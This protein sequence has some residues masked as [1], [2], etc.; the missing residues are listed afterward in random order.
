MRKVGDLF[1][2]G[3]VRVHQ[4]DLRRAAAVGNVGDA[5]GIGRPA[6]ALVGFAVVRDLARRAAGRAATIQI[7]CGFLLAA[8]SMVCTVK[9]THLPSGESCGSEIRFNS[10]MALTSNGRFWANTSTGTRRKKEKAPPHKHDCSALAERARFKESPAWVDRPFLGRLPHRAVG[11]R[12]RSLNRSV[13]LAPLDWTRTPSRFLAA[14]AG[15]ELLM[16]AHSL[17]K[18]AAS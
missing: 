8:T 5:L 16:A 14:L 9:A 12:F 1:G 2:V 7:W 17:K 3:A 10:I 15:R 13:Y 18:P 11:R 4:P 6:R